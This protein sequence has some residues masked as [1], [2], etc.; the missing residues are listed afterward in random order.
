[1]QL[2]AAAGMDFQY[3]DL[4]IK[5]FSA[6]DR[7]TELTGRA[8]NAFNSGFFLAADF[9]PFDM[10]SVNAGARYDFRMMDS[11][12]ENVFT[13]AF[14]YEAGAAFKPIDELNVYAKYST[15][16]RFPFLDEVADMFNGLYFSNDLNPEQGFNVEGG[17]NFVFDKWLALDANIYFMKLTDEIDFAYDDVLGLSRNLNLDPTER[18]GA[19]VSLSANPLDFLALQGSYSYVDAKFSDGVNKEKKIP[20][21]SAHEIS[22]AIAYTFPLNITLGIDLDYRGEAIQG[23]DFSNA[24]KK[25]DG[26]FLLGASLSYTLDKEN[27]HWFFLLRAKNLLDINYAPLISYDGYYPANG[28]EFNLSIQYRF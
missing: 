20:L 26:Y 15:L 18:I 8:V 2:D 10:L 19:S 28:R 1:M 22:A 17:I 6:N 4:N 24:Q 13:Q 21:V 23:G 5:T 3:S 14:V 12:S 16:F 11:E 25:I 27:Q 7:K 9:I